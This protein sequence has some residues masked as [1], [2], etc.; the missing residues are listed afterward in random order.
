MRLEQDRRRFYFYTI[1]QLS[2][3]EGEKVARNNG[4]YRQQLGCLDVR[5][6]YGN[7]RAGYRNWLRNRKKNQ[8][9]TRR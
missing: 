3:R 9:K 5:R 8:K 2:W 1:K 4:I 7:N 6:D